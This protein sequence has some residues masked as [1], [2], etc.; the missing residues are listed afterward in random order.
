[1]NQDVLIK[2]AE[3]F[4]ALVIT[5]DDGIEIIFDEKSLESYS[6]RVFAAGADYGLRV[7]Q[8]LAVRSKLG[9]QT[10]G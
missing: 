1:M 7:A 3:E 10:N 8:E 5:D 6:D 2:L 4:E 9:G